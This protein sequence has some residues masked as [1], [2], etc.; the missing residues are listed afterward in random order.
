MKASK[1]L[2]IGFFLIL[3]STIGACQSFEPTPSNEMDSLFTQAALT[4]Q[5][6]QTQEPTATIPPVSLTATASPTLELPSPTS[7]PTQSP[8]PTAISHCDWVAFVK[9]VTIPDGTV[10]ERDKTFTKT[11]RLKNRGT[12]T[13]TT[14]YSLVFRDGSLMDGPI[15]MSL[16]HNVNPGESVDISVSLKA[17]HKLGSYRGYWM[18][19]NSAGV[20]FGFGD[21]A[22]KAFFVDIRSG[23]DTSV[24]YV[25]GKVCFPSEHI[26]PMTLF[27]QRLSDNHLTQIPIQ[28]NQ[29]AYTTKLDPGDYNAY[30]WLDGFSLGGAYTYSM[31]NDHRLKP[32]TVTSKEDVRGID[33]CDWYGGP[34]SVPYPPNISGGMISGTLSYPSEFIPPL[35]VVAFNLTTGRYYWV[36]TQR[37]QVTYQISNLTPGTYHV[38]AYFQEAGSAAGYSIARYCDL[39]S[40]CSDHALIPIEIKVNSHVAGIDP[41]DWYAP[42]GT[43]PSDPTSATIQN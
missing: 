20:L 26:P 25:S 16:P 30:A 14:S 1:L 22:N 5:A 31:Q 10:I 7:T 38:V 34:G 4:V 28:E 13:W 39:N 29:T 15:N 19:R 11:W 9:D 12:C 17:P 40:S 18:L 6:M 23:S 35:R 32:F 27:F 33:I 42:I 3:T 2:T 21:S 37:D 41:V 36:D 24:S 43:F 8:P